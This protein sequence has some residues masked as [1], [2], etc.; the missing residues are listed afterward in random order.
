MREAAALHRWRD[1]HRPVAPAGTRPGC[2]KPELDNG[3]RPWVPRACAGVA[4][5]ARTAG[6]AGGRGALRARRARRPCTCALRAPRPLRG[7]RG[8]AAGDCAPVG[9]FKCVLKGKGRDQ[10]LTEVKNAPLTTVCLS[11]R[12]WKTPQ[13]FQN[14]FTF[15]WK[16]IESKKTLAFVRCTPP[17]PV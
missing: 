12:T 2:G 3:P 11:Q 13:N 6:N 4:D 5:G 17:K 16:R 15:F 1:S 8:S 10:D 9:A 14:W 7:S